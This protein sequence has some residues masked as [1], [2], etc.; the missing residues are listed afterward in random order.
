MIGLGILPNLDSALTG[1]ALDDGIHLVN[2]HF[3]TLNIYIIT[4]HV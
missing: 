1:F 2:A 3:I 4:T